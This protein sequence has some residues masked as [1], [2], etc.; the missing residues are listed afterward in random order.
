MFSYGGFALEIL[1]FMDYGKKKGLTND[2]DLALFV[3]YMFSI[4][5]RTS[6]P[7]S[8]VPTTLVP[9]VAISGVR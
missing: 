5:D 4:S 2:V 8:L 3:Y 9:S 7:A 1:L 6:A